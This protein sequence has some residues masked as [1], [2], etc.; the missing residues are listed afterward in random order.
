MATSYTSTNQVFVDASLYFAVRKGGGL[1]LRLFPAIARERWAWF[2]ENYNKSFKARF[3]AGATGDIFLLKRLEDL[4]K[5][6]Q[7]YNLGNTSINP[8]ESGANLFKFSP[9]LQAIGY[10]EL[11][12]TPAENAARDDELKRISELTE[13]DFRNML[14][15]LR[16]ITAITSQ[17][18]GLGDPTVEA[19]LGLSPRKKRR[20]AQIQ[21]IVDIAEINDAYK[22]IEGYIYDRQLTQ[23]KPPNLL[24]IAKRGVAPG[25]GFI[26][27]NVYQTYVPVPFEISLDSMAKKYLGAAQRWFEL[28]TINNLQPPFVDNVGEK[29]TPQAPPA[30]NNLIITTGTIENLAPGV[31]IGIGSNRYREETRIIE[32]VVANEDDTV[33]LFLGGKNDLNK[34]L[35]NEGAFIRVYKPGTVQENSIILIPS[36]GDSTLGP[37]KPTP[38]KDEIRRI[39]KAFIQFG[40]DIAKDEKTDDWIIDATGNFKL[41]Y[42]VNAIRQSVRQILR[43]NVN[44]LPYHPA[45]GVNY[46]LGKQF[47]GTVDEAVKIGELLV[48]SITKD[49]RI[50]DVVI[51]RISNTNTSTSLQLLVKIKGLDDPIPLSFVT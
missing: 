36:P 9:F 12:A 2:V 14:A 50:E 24:A 30:S 13:A 16:R 41:S 40:I 18:I 28:V 29:F 5:F 8:F 31:R 49:R 34:F 21:D 48:S 6:V 38:K 43:T 26:P 19:L 4:D 7:G 35:P 11:L 33:V 15:Y 27:A 51:S 39:E 10:G 17:E 37:A 32:K 47:V 45:F 22:F 3:Q 23:Q 42:G 44:E 20:S 46:E 25:S 1:S